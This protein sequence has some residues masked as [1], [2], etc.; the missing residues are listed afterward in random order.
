MTSEGGSGRAKTCGWSSH[1]PRLYGWLGNVVVMFVLFVSEMLVAGNCLVMRLA[2][3]HQLAAL[4]PPVYD[5]IIGLGKHN[6]AEGS[7]KY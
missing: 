3:T 1:P 7:V 5:M 2:L 4:R 6:L